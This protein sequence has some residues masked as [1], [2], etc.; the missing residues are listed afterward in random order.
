LRKSAL[1]EQFDIQLKAA[2]NHR[3][4]REY[5]FASPRRYRVDFAFVGLKVAVEVEGGTWS[6]GKSRHTTGAGFQK[7]CEKYN[8]LAEKG[9]LLVRGDSAMVK[10]GRLLEWVNRVCET[11]YKAIPF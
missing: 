9:W 1:E 8:L 3:F 10:D 7:D 6:R 2:C 4:I 11:A 5:R